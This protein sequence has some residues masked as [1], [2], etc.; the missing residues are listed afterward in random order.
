[1]TRY[2]PT[3][4]DLT[5]NFFVLCIKVKVYLF[6]YSEWVE[7]IVNIQ[8]KVKGGSRAYSISIKIPCTG[9]YG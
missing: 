7:L 1:M 5:S 3:L 8:E 2:D 9:S 4:A 6:N